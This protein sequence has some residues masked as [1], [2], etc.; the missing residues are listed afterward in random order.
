M[1]IVFP[2]ITRFWQTPNMYMVYLGSQQVFFGTPTQRIFLQNPPKIPLCGAA[3]GVDL[4]AEQRL[5]PVGR[6][7]FFRD[8]RG[9]DLQVWCFRYP[10]S[11]GV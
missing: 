11:G 6:F 1:I 9:E 4:V 7:F 10:S 3:V 8:I 2:T 5:S